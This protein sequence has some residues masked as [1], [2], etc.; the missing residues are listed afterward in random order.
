[1]ELTKAELDYEI[2]DEYKYETTIAFEIINNKHM[3]RTSKDRTGLFVI[4]LEFVI[5]LEIGKLNL[6]CCYHSPK[7]IF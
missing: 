2:R 1:M 3:A 6:N 7:E 5:T 4:L